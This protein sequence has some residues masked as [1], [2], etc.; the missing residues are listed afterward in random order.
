MISPSA[1]HVLPLLLSA[2]TLKNA[3]KSTVMPPIVH[4][5]ILLRGAYYASKG[6]HLK[7]DLVLHVKLKAVY[8]APHL[9]IHAKNVVMA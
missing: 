8:L 2:K 6:F 7:T 9:L 1:L 4:N 5:V 3:S